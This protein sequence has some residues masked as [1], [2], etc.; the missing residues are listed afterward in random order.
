MIVYGVVGA[1]VSVVVN[2]ML[3]REFGFNGVDAL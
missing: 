2:F 1:V 3:L